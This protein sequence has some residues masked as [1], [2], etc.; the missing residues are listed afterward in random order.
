M[1]ALP[2]GHGR[3]LRRRMMQWIL[4]ATCITCVLFALMPAGDNV[5]C[6]YSCGSAKQQIAVFGR[7]RRVTP[8]ANAEWLTKRSAQRSS[9]WGASYFPNPP[10]LLKL[11][12]VLLPAILLDWK[13]KA[14][15]VVFVLAVPVYTTVLRAWPGPGWLGGTPWQEHEPSKAS[16]SLDGAV[17]NPLGHLATGSAYKKYVSVGALLGALL[18]MVC[19]VAKV[20]YCLQVFANKGQQGARLAMA[21]SPLESMLVAHTFLLLAQIIM[22]DFHRGRNYPP[23]LRIL[24]PIAFNTVRL[25]VL[26]S[27]FCASFDANSRMMVTLAGGN[28]FFWLFNLLFF[29]IP[30]ALRAYAKAYFHHVESPAGERPDVAEETM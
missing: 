29:L 26:W 9:S 1:G 20:L 27:W 23:L 10:E 18:P 17:R 4:L 14:F 12:A 11:M 5:F 16:E 6:F 15:H 7:A 25:P 22:E 2:H 30:V 21:C 13:Q 8:R 24:I 28:F 19:F 3:A